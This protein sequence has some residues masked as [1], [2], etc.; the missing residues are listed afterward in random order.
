VNSD[1]IADELVDYALTKHAVDS[2]DF[3]DDIDAQKKS[4]RSHKLKL[5]LIGLGALGAGGLAAWGLSGDMGKRL[6]QLVGGTPDKTPLRK[7][8]M[9][10][11]NQGSVA[12][13][14]AAMFR[15]GWAG[16]LAGGITPAGESTGGRF[17]VTKPGFAAEA[18]TS[19]TGAGLL[20]RSTP[21]RISKDISALTAEKE[22]PVNWLRSAMTPMS[23]SPEAKNTFEGF[24][25]YVDSAAKQPAPAEGSTPKGVGKKPSTPTVDPDAPI[26]QGLSRP[27]D[28]KFVSLA[29]KQ[30]E[31]T[32][33][34]PMKASASG[35][36]VQDGDSHIPVSAS[37][38]NADELLRAK[39]Y[40]VEITPRGYEMK[41]LGD[42]VP[43]LANQINVAKNTSVHSSDMTPA[44]QTELFM[45]KQTTAPRVSEYIKQF[46]PLVVEAEKA[47]NRATLEAKTDPAKAPQRE[48]AAAA[49]RR[50]TNIYNSLIG[51][52]VNI[53]QIGTHAETGYEPET[54]TTP[55]PKRTMNLIAKRVSDRARG[56]QALQSAMHRNRYQAGFKPAFGRGL[57]TGLAVGIPSFGLQQFFGAGTGTY[58]SE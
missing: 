4:D 36:Y 12:G 19:A 16:R 40:T 33:P 44:R 3:S 22:G 6:G 56:F 31:S 50:A 48:A 42:V 37:K 24:K 58:L 8:L 21:D 11:L 26:A 7:I 49:Y 35:L 27:L 47:L 14:A 28:P 18:V 53:H 43:D 10:P 30:F 15:S 41:P 32:L 5:A 29:M 45:L 54:K 46:E 52:L 38:L 55:S 13:G 9:S 34:A 51:D 1:L 25:T 2:D 17:H 57:R 39:L 23:T 20:P